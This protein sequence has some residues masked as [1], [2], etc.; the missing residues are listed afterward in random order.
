MLGRDYVLQR[1][2]VALPAFD[3]VALGHI[4][5]H[6]VLGHHPPV[7]YS[8]SLQPVDFSEEDDV[9]GFC[10][11]EIDPT[12]PQGE[13]AR[14]ELVPVDA[15]PMVTI[16]VTVPPDAEDPTALVTRTIAR[17]HIVGAIVRVH[18]TVPAE[19]APQL[20]ERTVREALQDAHAVAAVTREVVQERPTRLGQKAQGMGPIDALR[21]YLES[22]GNLPEP[23]E[24]RAMEWGT[25]LIEEELGGGTAAGGP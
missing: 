10:L 25:R 12:L 19:L 18:V 6:Q 9:K 5:K 24:Q 13:R 22:R 17:R 14:W 7:V 15:R 3:Y 8:G 20:N 21:W 2:S 23:S 1:S 4:H 11:V 16:R